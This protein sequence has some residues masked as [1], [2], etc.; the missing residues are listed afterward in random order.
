M[1]EPMPSEAVV[2][3]LRD[4]VYGQV[5]TDANWD[6]CRDKWMNPAD[7]AWLRVRAFKAPKGKTP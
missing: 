5:S 7:I 1:S 4:L 2:R 3:Q 6:A